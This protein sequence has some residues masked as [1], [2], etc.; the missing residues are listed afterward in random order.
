M[1][2]ALIPPADSAAARIPRKLHAFAHDELPSLA[3]GA[4]AAAF[5]VCIAVRLPWAEDLMLHLAV[6][7]RLALDPS[8]PGNPVLDTGGSSI[9]YSPY[10]LALALPAKAFGLSAASLYKA[11]AIINVLLLLTGVFRF[12][13]T[14]SD[15]RWAPALTL[16][17]LFLWWGTSTIAWSGFLSLL[18]LADT[19][20]YPST[21]ATALA[22]HLWAGLNDR[23]MHGL[24]SR[25]RMAGLGALYGIIVLTHQF[26]AMNAAIGCIAIL[27]SRHRVVRSRKALAA[28]GVGLAVC[29]AIVVAWPYYHLWSVSQG[30][31]DVLD[32][33]HRPLYAHPAGWYGMGLVLGL[34]AVAL[35][36]RRSRTDVLALIFLGAGAVAGYGW[37]SGHWAYGRCWPMVMLAGQ[38]SLAIALAEARR[39]LPRALWAAVT[40]VITIVGVM[41]QAGAA[42]YLLPT[43]WQPGA[44]RLLAHDP[45]P[46]RAFVDNE[47]RLDW[48]DRY[49][50]S[51]DVVAADVREAQLEIAA[52][53]AYDMTSPWYLPEV[54]EAAWEQR[55]AAV[56]ALFAPGTPT[57]ERIR[58]LRTYHVDRLLLTGS[59]QPPPGIGAELT[60][61]GDGFALYEVAA[62]GTS[63]A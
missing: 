9:Y 47:P 40:A 23:G 17:G 49:L 63:P 32:P 31:L 33:V 37:V 51:D 42:V 2:L 38:A 41:T 14:L 55:N 34:V 18:S 26:T 27:I 59:E 16:I 57:A 4:V 52:H 1:A 45:A 39:G 12:V 19:E 15:A 20:A 11:A 48:L 6:L 3:T 22:L 21:L 44:R 56:A 28:L 43:A 8:H 35:R 30:Q 62:P 10:M 60:A 24:T 5:L 61:R 13:R 29:A 54:P 53:G 46:T 7:H 58:L 25:S 50:R 36:L